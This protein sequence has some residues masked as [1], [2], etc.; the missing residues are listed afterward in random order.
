MSALHTC[1]SSV[2]R[3]AFGKKTSKEEV[4]WWWVSALGQQVISVERDIFLV[5]SALLCR[6][7]HLDQATSERPESSEHLSTR[8]AE[9]EGRAAK[10]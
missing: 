6:A 10:D 5:G 3:M 8:S 4:Q 7:L 2:L 9:R 1:V